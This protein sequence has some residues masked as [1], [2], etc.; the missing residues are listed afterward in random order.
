MTPLETKGEKWLD[1]G[2]LGWL[3][4]YDHSD[5]W[6]NFKAYEVISELVSEPKTKS[7]RKPDTIE[8]TENPDEAEPTISGYVKWDGCCEMTGPTPHF[9]GAQDVASYTK[10]M[11]ELHRLCLLLPAVDYD[12]AGYP[13]PT[14]SPSGEKP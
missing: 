10:V 14:D 3:V 6:L 11:Q 2:C 9:C 13:E 5:H 1:L 4:R 12:C 8:H 7:F